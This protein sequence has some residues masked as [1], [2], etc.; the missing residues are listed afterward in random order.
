MG[1][2]GGIFLMGAS[3]PAAISNRLVRYIDPSNPKA[4]HSWQEFCATHVDPV[5]N[6]LEADGTRATVE[7][8]RWPGHT[9]PNIRVLAVDELPRTKLYGDKWLYEGFT[10]KARLYTDS[11]R[12]ID[13]H[14]GCPDSA[15][16]AGTLI[17]QGGG[18]QLMQL[19][20]DCYQPLAEAGCSLVMDY[21]S[22]QPANSATY[23]EAS[24]MRLYGVRVILESTP[25]LSA[26]HWH[27]WPCQ[28]VYDVFK[29]RHMTTDAGMRARFAQLGTDQFKRIH[30]DCRVDVWPASFATKD[31]PGMKRLAGDWTRDPKRADAER[32]ACLSEIAAAVKPLVAGGVRVLLSNE[33]IAAAI[34]AKVSVKEF[35]SHA[36]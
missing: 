8:S 2:V 10:E 7:F 18:V 4:A 30:P 33:I 14:F 3:D 28:C 19:L 26:T 16:V 25:E 1:Q 24:R 6:W 20:H 12:E 31:L 27:G 5:I 21:S 32:R 11:R 13:V 23:L 22:P 29:R 17:K 15:D 9:D 35:S 36:E 34:E